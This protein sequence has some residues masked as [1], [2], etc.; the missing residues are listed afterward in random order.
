M[1]TVAFHLRILQVRFEDKTIVNE[2][3]CHI[4]RGALMA[5]FACP[6]VLPAQ[7]VSSAAGVIPASA[8]SISVSQASLVLPDAPGLSLAASDARTSA[9][10]LQVVSPANTFATTTGATLPVASHTDKYIQPGQAVPTLTVRDKALLGIRDAFSPFA[11]VGWFVSAG[12]DQAFNSSPNYGSDRGAF[13]QRLGAAVLRDA[14]EG[15]FSDSVMSS[16]LREDPRYYRLGPSHG[17]VA[18][19]VYAGT[20]PVIGRTDGGRTIPNLA[21]L[22]GTLAGAAMASAYYPPVNR[23][24]TQTMEIFGGSLGTSAL[25]DVVSEFFDDVFGAIHKRK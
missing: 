20:R 6:F 7:V 23:G 14:S 24:A 17:F 13:G 16:V 21:N 4:A 8:S 12:Y 22:S 10:S 18:R 25:G 1:R 2:S 5:S 3:L 15:I 9:D 11:A 19:L